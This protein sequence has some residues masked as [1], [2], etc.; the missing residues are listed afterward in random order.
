MVYKLQ[1]GAKRGE[2]LIQRDDGSEAIA[3]LK[4][5]FLD[6]VPNVVVDEAE[7]KVVEPLQWYQWLWAGLPILLVFGGGALGG[8]LGFL[9]ANIRCAF[10]SL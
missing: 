3:K 1:K 7:I 5:R 4:Y 2:Y 9:A 10:I 6:P 8:A